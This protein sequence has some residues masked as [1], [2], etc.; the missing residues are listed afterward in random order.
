M[1]GL[2]FQSLTRK[3]HE[4]RSS[5]NGTKLTAVRPKG[6]WSLLTDELGL[7]RV[8]LFYILE[9]WHM[10]DLWENLTSLQNL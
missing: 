2:F 8:V 7:D 5:T 1:R 3:G 6:G 9:S 10:T 4:G